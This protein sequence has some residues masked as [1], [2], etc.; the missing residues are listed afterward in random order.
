VTI[1]ITLVASVNALKNNFLRERAVRAHGGRSLEFVAFLDGEEAGF[2]SYEDWPDRSQGFIFEVLVLPSFRQQGIGQSLLLHA[3]KYA[4]D[5]GRKTLKLKPYALDQA[6]DTIRLIS[7]Y[8]Q[9][10]YVQSPDEEGVLQ[11]YLAS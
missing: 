8:K 9:V 10:G 6:T 1:E 4:T 3:E 7:W 2:L 5:Q 11:K